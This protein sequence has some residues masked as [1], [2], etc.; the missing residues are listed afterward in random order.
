MKVGI[1]ALFTSAL[2]LQT[3]WSVKE[4]KLYTSRRR[5]DFNLTCISWAQEEHAATLYLVRVDQFV[6][7]ARQVDAEA[8]MSAPKNPEYS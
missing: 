7:G 4:V 6:D 1:E 8:E 3:H 2:G 5:I